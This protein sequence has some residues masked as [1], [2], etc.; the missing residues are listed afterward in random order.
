M[1]L[2]VALTIPV[3]GGEELLVPYGPDSV[4]FVVGANG[5]GK[6]ALMVRFKIALGE[7][8]HRIV[9]A[10]P[11]VLQADAPEIPAAQAVN[12]RRNISS[13]DSDYQHRAKMVGGDQR[14]QMYLHTL[15]E[16]ESS[17]QRETRAAF[18]AVDLHANDDGAVSVEAITCLRELQSSHSPLSRINQALRVSGF[19][20]ELKI[21]S[22]GQVN[23]SKRA[24]VEF[25]VSQTSDG[26]R[27]ALILLIEAMAASPQQILL[28]DEPERHIH[29]SLLHPLL[30]E[31]MRLRSDCSFIVSTHDIEFVSNFVGPVVLL[32][33]MVRLNE[34]WIAD[35]VTDSSVIDDMVREDILGGRRKVLFVEG[36]PEGTD[37]RLYNLLFDGIS[38]SAKGSSRTVIEAT[39]GSR[40][41]DGFAWLR[42][43]GIIDRDGRTDDEITRLRGQG[44]WSLP[45]Y[46]V[47]SIYYHPEVIRHV[48]DNAIAPNQGLEAENA[49]AVA[50]RAAR[51]RLPRL[52]GRGVEKSIRQSIIKSIPKWDMFQTT[53][54][55]EFNTRPQEMY[56]QELR[57]LTAAID[58]SDW[59]TIVSR[60]PVRETGARSEIA[61]FLGFS[62]AIEYEDAVRESLATHDGFRAKVRELLGE[63][64]DG[65]AYKN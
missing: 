50:C 56:E 62:N 65:L 31:L 41:I 9:A 28:I 37:E 19:L 15:T 43:W 14:A 4:T 20:I 27:A 2:P 5:T 25:G 32:R 18:E 54:E 36:K 55:I 7:S 60:C 23:A 59:T 33:D 16:L 38:V 35:L 10:R 6:S 17:F 49:L 22:D 57:T 64:L 13:W 52:A 51:P 44:I 12:H 63:P 24:G 21:A 34:S 30:L 8:G 26:E 47:E 58:Q 40:G 61:K 39:R 1:N 42:A 53:E 48:V 46:S 11:L 3:E 29:R 45:L